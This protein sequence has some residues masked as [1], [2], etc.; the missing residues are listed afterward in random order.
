MTMG[1]GSKV[2]ELGEDLIEALELLDAV[3]NYETR[4]VLGP[5]WSRKLD[6]LK[7]KY[8]SDDEDTTPPETSD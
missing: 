2:F 7:A 8:P 6:A 5:E 1:M 4:L 3:D